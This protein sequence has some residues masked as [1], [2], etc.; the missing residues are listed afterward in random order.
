MAKSL[1][2]SKEMLALMVCLISFST[3]F[4]STLMFFVERGH[5]DERLGYYGERHVMRRV[6]GAPAGQQ[7]R[8]LAHATCA[9][10][11]PVWWAR[12]EWGLCQRWS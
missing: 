10:A 9:P 3:L 5:M 4:F 2:K 8:V 6:H 12:I 11:T 7:A 1:A